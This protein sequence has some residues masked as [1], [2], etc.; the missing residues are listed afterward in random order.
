MDDAQPEGRGSAPRSPGPEKDSLD[1]LISFSRELGSVRSLEEL[2]AVVRTALRQLTGADGATF[3]LR[4]G[5]LCRYADEDAVGP[6]WKGSRSAR[7]LNGIAPA[8]LF[9][10]RLLILVDLLSSAYRIGPKQKQ[11]GDGE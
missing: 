3:V 9:R 4:E 10:S 6:L 11:T 1:S 7:F 5:D 2:M 8:N